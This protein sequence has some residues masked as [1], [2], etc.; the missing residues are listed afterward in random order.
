[1]DATGDSGV[2][3]AIVDITHVD[4]GP[5]ARTRIGLQLRGGLTTVPDPSISWIAY[6]VVVDLDGDGQ[7]DQRIGI[8][9]TTADHREWITDLAT[10]QTAVNA[11]P[12][13]GAF[14]GFGTRLET[15]F[16]D[17]DGLATV[18]V[19]RTAFGFRFYA[20]ASMIRDGVVVATD[21]APDA[22]WID[23]VSD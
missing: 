2:P 18:V 8:D 11:G 19:K 9:N 22:G 13:Y 6:G 14:E 4:W 16:V 1:M 5:G 12:T 21:F 20:W 17:A 15:W 3:N 23:T 7:G 10:G